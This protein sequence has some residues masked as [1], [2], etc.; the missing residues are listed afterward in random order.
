MA[1]CVELHS[2]KGPYVLRLGGFLEMG[3][4]ILQ[5]LNFFMLDGWEVRSYA[6]IPLSSNK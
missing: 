2:S 1:T 6:K 5:E 4:S 3:L